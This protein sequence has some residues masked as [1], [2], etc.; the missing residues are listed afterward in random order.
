MHKMQPCPWVEWELLVL[1][2]AK[3]IA[4]LRYHTDSVLLLLLVVGEMWLEH[5]A[6]VKPMYMFHFGVRGLIRR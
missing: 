6:Y 4:N 3:L 2:T 5:V 1:A